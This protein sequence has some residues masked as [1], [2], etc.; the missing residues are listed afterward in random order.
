MGEDGWEGGGVSE[1]GG[2]VGGVGRGGDRW[3]WQLV[4][5]GLLKK[6]CS[7]GLVLKLLLQ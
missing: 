3:A 7:L 1:G 6:M 2:V 5:V 4:S